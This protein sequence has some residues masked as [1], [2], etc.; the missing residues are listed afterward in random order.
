MKTQY[1]IHPVLCQRRITFDSAVNAIFGTKWADV[2]MNGTESGQAKKKRT[3]RKITSRSRSCNLV[4]HR[5][6]GNMYDI[7]FINIPYLL[8]KVNRLTRRALHW[9]FAHWRKPSGALC[10]C[11]ISDLTSLNTKSNIQNFLPSLATWFQR[12]FYAVVRFV[13][14]RYSIF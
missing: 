14:V 3:E 11:S 4:S 2:W 1:P 13:A 9:A 12:F 5:V 7:C 6:L 10:W 8:A